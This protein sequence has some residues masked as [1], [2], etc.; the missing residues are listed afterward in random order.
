[1]KQL[2][3][4]FCLF[5]LALSAG[6]PLRVASWNVENLF[7]TVDDPTNEGDDQFLPQDSYTRWNEAKYARKLQNLAEL[8]AA[9]K[10]DILCLVEIENRRVLV[11]LQQA[12]L[13]QRQ[14][15]LPHIVHRDSQDKRGIDVAILSR[16]APTATEWLAGNTGGREMLVADFKVDGAPLTLFVNHWK[17]QA[18]YDGMK[19]TDSDALRRSEAQIS[20]RA[21]AARLK[22][23]PAAAILL[24]GD[25]ND[26]IDCDI[27]EKNAGLALKREMLRVDPTLLF[28]LSADLPAKA[29]GTYYY[30]SGKKWN[31]FDSISVSA[32]MLDA[33]T[34]A[35]PWRV[36]PGSYTLF[37]FPAHLDDDGRPSPFRFVRSKAKGNRFIYGYSDH[38]PVCVA[39]ER[40]PANKEKKP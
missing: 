24:T 27:L 29:R 21:V 39:L 26:N 14:V 8:V 10:P 19:K 37:R 1:M 9:L 11:D 12:L 15:D 22:K 28:N 16:H 38:L 36:V 30:A 34:P 18:L 2:L 25:L 3:T 20:R 4:L 23:N 31:S 7:D 17:S 35:A 32:G 5:A 13:R 40:P 33:F 6:E